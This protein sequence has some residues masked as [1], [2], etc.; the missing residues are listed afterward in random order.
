MP[1]TYPEDWVPLNPNPPQGIL[2]HV[3]LRI[4][5]R[6]ITPEQVTE[7][8]TWTE[9][10][11]MVPPGDWYKKFPNLTVVGRGCFQ[12][13]VLKKGMK[14]WGQIVGAAEPDPVTESPAFKAWF[15]QSKVVDAQGNPCVVYHGTDKK[16]TVFNKNKSIMGLFWFTNTKADIE[17]GEVGAAGKGHI[18]DLYASVQNPAGWKDYE[19]YGIG[20]LKS[21]GYDG[22]LLVDGDGSFTGFVFDPKQLKSASRNRGAYDAGK[23]S[24]LAAKGFK[25]RLLSTPNPL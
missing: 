3:E 2:D 15:R 24:I 10:R 1:L 20:E 5:E 25:S 8:I 18:L 14:P 11:P 22:A 21:L 23:G 17:A 19:R 4:R 9:K 7:F 13:S 6:S 16:F 12:K